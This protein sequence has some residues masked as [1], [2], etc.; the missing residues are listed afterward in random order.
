MKITKTLLDPFTELANTGKLTGVLLILAT[1]A[2]LIITNTQAGYQYLDIWHFS[3]GP[4]FFFEPLELWINDGLM[5]VFFFLVGLEIK[6][7]LLKGQLSDRKRALLPAVA[8]AGGMLM[9]ALI[10]ASMNFQSSF[11][12][13]WAIPTATDIAFSLG[14]L[15]LFGNRVPLSLKVFLTA[16]A[17]IDDLG[18]VVIIAFFYSS[19]INF[20]CLLLGAACLAAIYVLNRFKFHRFI[21]YLP[22]GM[23]LWFFIF[24]SGVHATIAGVLFAFMIPLPMIERLEHNLHKPVNYFIMPLF[25]LANTAIV[26]HTDNLAQLFS[27]LSFGIV[28]GLLIGKPLGIYFFSWLAVKMKWGSLPDHIGH[29]HLLGIGCAAGIGFTMSIFIAGLSFADAIELDDAKLSVLAGSL[30]S[31]IAAWIILA[32]RNKKIQS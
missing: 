5:A 20:M 19:E 14:I 32:G 17:I 2:S 15:S 4:K 16:L 26:L 24:E 7:E 3:F 21:F 31:A 10:F 6:R 1:T 8:A 25:A 30:L 22:L 12:R 29:K 23:L 13:G 28:A 11:M 18:A 27:T 9:P